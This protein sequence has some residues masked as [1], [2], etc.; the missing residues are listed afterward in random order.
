MPPG[1][2]QPILDA[3]KSLE[4][5]IDSLVD[6]VQE[7]EKDGVKNEA[8]A[9]TVDDHEERI[10]TLEKLAPAMKVVIWIAGALGLSVIGL[11]WGLL[12]G[13]IALVFN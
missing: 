9:K 1:S 8:V 3:L 12:T 10:R 11:I 5:K 2:I 4:G 7:L 6:K 13:Q